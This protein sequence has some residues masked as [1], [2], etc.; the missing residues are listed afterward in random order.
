MPTYSL[1]GATGATGSAILRCLIAE[2][3]PKLKLNIFVR[4]KEK[5]LKSFPDLQQTSSISIDVTEGT[6]TDTAALRTCLRDSEVVFMCIATNE[7]IPNTSVSY[8]TASAIVDSLKMLREEKDDAFK[9][10]TL[11]QLRTAGLNPD[12]DGHRTASE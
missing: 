1:L 3:S 11:L 9:K 6:G 10:P 7:S 4:S 8:D 12:M 2:A 5:L